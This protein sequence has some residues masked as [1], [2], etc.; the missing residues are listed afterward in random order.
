M[1]SEI[2]A[3]LR[4]FFAGMKETKIEL[5]D[6]DIATATSIAISNSVIPIVY[7]G[8]KKPEKKSD[9]FARLRKEMLTACSRQ[10]V[11]NEIL[12][13]F[14]RKL[15]GRCIAYCIVKGPAVAKYYPSPDMRTSS[16]FDILIRADQVDA[17]KIAI[18]EFGGS[19][20]EQLSDNNCIHAVFEKVLH[21]E[22]HLTLFEDENMLYA[23]DF[24]ADK[25]FKEENFE[26]IDTD[27]VKFVSLK[28]QLQLLYLICHSAL[29]FVNAG[30]GI[31]QLADC[32]VY[33]CANYD[34]ID[35][36]L[37][38]EKLKE[39]SLLT[40]A[41]TVFSIGIN[42]CG[43]DERILPDFAKKL[44]DLAEILLEDAVDGGSFGHSNAERAATTTV[45]KSE[46]MS[47]LNAV[48]P[49]KEYLKKRYP[50]KSLLSAWLKRIMDYLKRGENPVKT[51]NRTVKIAQER[52]KLIGE[53]E[54]YSSKQREPKKIGSDDVEKLFK[55]EERIKIR[56]AGNSMAPF[57]K[58]ARDFVVLEKFSGKPIKGEIYFY[59][60]ACGQLVMHRLI[61]ING[62]ELQ[63]CGDSQLAIEVGIKKEMIFACAAEFEINGKS[64]GKKSIKYLFF[65]KVWSCIL[66]RKIAFRILSLWKKR[67]DSI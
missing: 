34:V 25:V 42:Y 51:V 65:S 15:E 8:I 41:E 7:A 11:M 35:F 50:N 52:M 22:I 14:I 5:S 31:R 45:T 20:N 28:P 38:F 13:R 26:R 18:A 16:D 6:E 43:A 63:M 36:E 66:L 30:C 19:I 61:K 29:H 49:P 24:S 3:F 56:I 47:F 12:V 58:N 4:A 48:F 23:S 46:N 44:D 40:F 57:L 2:S 60:R 55:N 1:K 37:L 62:D 64:I 59:R 10:A 67:K 21:L 32:W 54:I 17:V 9:A 53:L 33:A 39:Y 27:G